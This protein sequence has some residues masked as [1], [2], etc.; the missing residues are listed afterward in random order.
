MIEFRSEAAKKGFYKELKGCNNNKL[1]NGKVMKFKNNMTLRERIR[2]TR[3]GQ[4]K[5]RLMNTTGIDATQIKIDWQE[6]KIKYKLKVIF[7]IDVDGKTHY[8]DEG[9]LVKTD[10]EH[11]MKE[12][13]QRREVQEEGDLE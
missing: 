1:Q 6:H 12:W 8:D 10:V 3:L 13:C 11:F 7:H 2:D 9:T 4:I 5:H